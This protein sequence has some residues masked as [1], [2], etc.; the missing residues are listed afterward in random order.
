[1]RVLILALALV[2]LLCQ[3]VA[4]WNNKGHMLVAQLAYQRLTPE[5]RQAV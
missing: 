3:P 1:M 4:A 5:Q 2:A